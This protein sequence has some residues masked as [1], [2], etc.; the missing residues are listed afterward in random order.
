[1]QENVL[2]FLHGFL[3]TGDD[4][5]AIMKAMSGSARCISVDLPGHG[6]SILNTSKVADQEL[7][8]SL[9]MVAGLLHNLIHHITT[10]KVT[11]VGYSM[12][13]R[14]ALYMTLKYGYKV[15][16]YIWCCISF[17]IV[18]LIDNLNLYEG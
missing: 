12:G 4:W 17:R 3:G 13:A 11:L 1:M 7:C 14:I 8:L 2:V 5:I 18:S 16:S 15:W 10:E 6:E 9:E